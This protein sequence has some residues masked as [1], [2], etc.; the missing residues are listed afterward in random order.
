LNA[1]TAKTAE[2]KLQDFCEDHEKDVRFFFVTF[3]SFVASWSRFESSLRVLPVER[4]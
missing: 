3:E 4:P 1:E 2:K